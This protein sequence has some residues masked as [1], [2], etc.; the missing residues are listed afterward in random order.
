MTSLGTHVQRLETWRAMLPLLY[1][2]CW[3]GSTFFLWRREGS[4]HWM[5][6]ECR[7]GLRKSS[8]DLTLWKGW[9]YKL[10]R[11]PQWVSRDYFGGPGLMVVPAASWLYLCG[12]ETWTHS[13]LLSIISRSFYLGGRP[14]RE[15]VRCCRRGWW[16]WRQLCSAERLTLFP[17]VCEPSAQSPGRVYIHPLST[18]VSVRF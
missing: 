12:L 17:C 1:A 15:S 6:Q 10:L 9:V 16:G 3:I 2:Q 13:L 14:E 18:V 7:L 5:T 11:V 8:E 4:W